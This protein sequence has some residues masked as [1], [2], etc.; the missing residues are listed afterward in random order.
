[1]YISEIKL[2]NF[3][4]YSDKK[5]C[6][7]KKI[8]LISD[9]FQ[10]G[11]TTIFEAFK[12]VL[13]IKGI[14]FSPIGEKVETCVSCIISNGQMNYSIQKTSKPKFKNG[15]FEK[16]ETKYLYDDMNI[17]TA[18]EYHGIL[19][20]LFEI[21]YDYLEMLSDITFF[22]EKLDKNK[23]KDIFNN[24]FDLDKEVSCIKNNFKI[25]DEYFKKGY[26]EKEIKEIILSKKRKLEESVSNCK[27]LL[28]N[29][30]KKYSSYDKKYF[31]DLK[32]EREDILKTIS[33]N[34][35]EDEKNNK[36]FY[37]DLKD[38]E[39]KISSCKEKNIE[40]NNKY[41]RLIKIEN[42]LKNSLFKTN[43]EI[44]NI[45]NKKVEISSLIKDLKN[46]IN[47]N[48]INDVICNYCGSKI[49]DEKKEKF[50]SVKKEKLDNM[51]KSK[52]S[53]TE[54][55]EKIQNQK[56]DLKKKINTNSK[57]KKE[58]YE[59]IEICK[60]ELDSFENKKNN[61][62]PVKDFDKLQLDSFIEESLIDIN[63]KI[64]EEDFFLKTKENIDKI[65]KDLSL[66]TKKLIEI[67]EESEKLF[68]YNLE[69]SKIQDYIVSKNFPKSISFSF[70]TEQSSK[71][72]KSA[73]LG[74]EC[75]YN[76]IK[77]TEG[78]SNGQKIHANIIVN[79]SLQNKLKCN[80]P[81]FVD[82]FQDYNDIVNSSRQVILIETVCKNKNKIDKII[83]VSK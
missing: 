46:E 75:F 62:Y 8:N 32:K 35:E 44:T 29:E 56:E 54:Y 51:I 38:I 37:S 13:D 53:Y 19:E 22:N 48:K 77:Y 26:S 63:K 16:F 72:I 60:K 33:K 45:S 1:M 55:I 64:S 81:I 10:T 36:K 73:K 66:E 57:S 9:E 76:G 82:N 17:K 34:N 58:F 7:S 12:Y 50:I 25:F 18:K 6:F 49:S 3:K 2:K 79:E 68:E 21:K 24:L 69:K 74:C 39:N 40:L 27:T 20:T 71:A 31:D 5:I 23:R 30:N 14:P 11:K 4:C 78:C 43:L 61:L 15:V 83:G 42:N 65:K 70:S 28:E 41:D 52:Q 80:I 67:S 47:E 59:K